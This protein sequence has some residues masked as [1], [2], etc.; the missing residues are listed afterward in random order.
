M[1]KI[2]NIKNTGIL[3]NCCTIAGLIL[4]GIFIIYGIK[5]N[6]FISQSALDDFLSKL[7]L[8]APVVFI[9]IQAI[10]V[11]FPILPG[12]IGC[13]GGVLVFGPLMGFVYNYIGICLGSV[14][15]FVISRRY[16]VVF[17]KN[18]IS[19]KKYEKY[20]EWL[21]KKNFDMFFAAA[22]FFP[23][24]PDDILCFI[25][26]LTKMSF[27]KFII[28]ILAGKPFAIFLYSAGL[29]YAADILIGILS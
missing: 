29:K 22:I 14:M 4:T 10:Q 11:V 23:F 5:S 18:L 9:G 19:I 13:L 20:S 1:N 28:I 27:V 6:I 7:G 8:M 15:A 26:G 24:A 3:L 25:A 16:G 21:E 17:V 2:I 12:S